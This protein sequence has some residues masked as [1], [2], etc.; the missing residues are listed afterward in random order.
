MARPRGAQEP[1]GAA[2]QGRA[3]DLQRDHQARGHRGDGRAARA[4]YRSDRRLSCAPCARLSRRLH[5][6]P[7]IVAQAAGGEIG[8][9]RPVGRAAA[10]RRSRARDRA[11]PLAG[12]LV[13]HRDDGAGRHAV[14]RAPRPV[15]RQEAR[16][17]VDRR[18]GH[19][20]ARQGRCRGRA[21]R[22][23]VSRD[24]AGDAQPA[25]ALHHLDAAAGG[26]AQA[27]LLGQP[28]DADRAGALRGRRDHLYADRRR[29][30]GRFRHLRRAPRRRRSL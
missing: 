23:P 11:V 9:A 4:R 6:L 20:Q 27:R 3:R 17:P 30:D 25:A 15:G 13:G 29:A 10:D 16:S 28:H 26:R 18:R 19:R 7:R 5:A 14:R 21:L 24:Q 12:I 1:Q 22:G 2:R 8:R